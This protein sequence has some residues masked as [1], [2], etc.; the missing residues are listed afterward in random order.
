MRRMFG[1]AAMLL[2][3]LVGGVATN[4]SDAADW[5]QWRGLNR[6]GVWTETGLVERFESR[7]CPSSGGRRLAAA[8][9]ARPLPRGG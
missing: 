6:D 2:V 3:I 9:A 5:P 8:T 1:G 4:L 7:N